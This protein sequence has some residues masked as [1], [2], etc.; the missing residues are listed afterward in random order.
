MVGDG[1][2]DGIN[3]RCWEEALSVQD[4]LSPS[5][6]GHTRLSMMLGG[7]LAAAASL[8]SLTR[9]CERGIRGLAFPRTLI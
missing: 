9:R 5:V 6:P 3:Q 7:L 2:S 4:M 8:R 1:V